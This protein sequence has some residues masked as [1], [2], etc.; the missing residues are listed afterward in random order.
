MPFASP[1]EYSGAAPNSPAAVP[2]QVAPDRTIPTAP[3][4][5][6]EPL[7]R[8][9]VMQQWMGRPTRWPAGDGCQSRLGIGY[10]SVSF[11]TRRVSLTGQ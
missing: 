8:L 1:C 10:L 7:V 9:F 5:H 3:S 2:S 6:G 4:A 11:V